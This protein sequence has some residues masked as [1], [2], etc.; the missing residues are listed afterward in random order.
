MASNGADIN[1]FESHYLHSLESKEIS[2]KS[3]NHA[4]LWLFLLQRDG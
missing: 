1:M 3:T 4:D 2:Q